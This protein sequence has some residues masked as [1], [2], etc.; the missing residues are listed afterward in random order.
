MKIYKRC[1]YGGVSTNHPEFS[2]GDDD[3]LPK[4]EAEDVIDNFV[5][6]Y[7]PDV[8]K[9]FMSDGWLNKWKG[10]YYMNIETSIFALP[11]EL[12]EDEWYGWFSRLEFNYDYDENSQT[13]SDNDKNKNNM[14]LLNNFI[15]G[16][17]IFNENI[18]GWYYFNSVKDAQRYEKIWKNKKAGVNNT[19]K[20]YWMG[21]DSEGDPMLFADSY[22]ASDNNDA[23]ETAFDITG[24]L[25]WVYEN[26]EEINRWSDLQNVLDDDNG[27]IPD[28][29]TKG[30][31][32]IWNRVGEPLGQ[33][34]KSRYQFLKDNYEQYGLLDE[35]LQMYPKPFTKDIEQTPG[36]I[37]NI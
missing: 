10:D 11:E 19:Y 18:N 30:G 36:T 9:E 22:T 24:G 20:V 28:I 1:V 29:I 7:M 13:F 31:R 12:D 35:F 25:E 26:F 33:Y 8:L 3:V 32:V 5:N 6:N 4:E 34:L 27:I 21:D 15:N 14:K 37:E 16:G 17:Q 23:I 2:Y